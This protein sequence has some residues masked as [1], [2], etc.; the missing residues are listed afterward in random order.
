MWV[1]I[2]VF[3]VILALIWRLTGRSKGLP[4]GPTCY[5]IIGNVGHFKPLEALQAHIN[6]RKKYGDI[7]TVMIFHKPMIIVHGYENIRELLLKHGDIFSDRPKT[8]INGVFN[9]EEG[10]HIP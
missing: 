8:I 1:T 9:K 6:L 2:A 10:I 4:P 3:A 7:Y 5:P